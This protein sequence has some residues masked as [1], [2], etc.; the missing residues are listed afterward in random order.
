MPPSARDNSACWSRSATSRTELWK[1]ALPHAGEAVEVRGQPRLNAA[2]HPADSAA[3]A[4]KRLFRCTRR[5]PVGRRGGGAG[6]DTAREDVATA[7]AARA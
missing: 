2:A 1:R 5:V 4:D 7:W 6:R 3:E